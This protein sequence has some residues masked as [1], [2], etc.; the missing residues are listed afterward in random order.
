VKKAAIILAPALLVCA[1]LFWASP[2][3]AGGGHSQLSCGECHFSHRPKD[4]AVEEGLGILWRTTHTADGLPSFRPYSSRSFDALRTDIG[5]PDGTSKLCLGCH[6]GSYAGLSSRA[7]FGVSDLSRSHPVSF[8]YDSALASRVRAGRLND[9]NTT[10]SG[11]GGTIAQDLLDQQGKMQCTSC[12]DVHASGADSKM[13][14]YSTN[15]TTGDGSRICRI[16]HN[17]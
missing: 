2:A 16:C 6:D 7:V 14:R 4:M 9:P 13:L 15:R 17:M 1:G 3:G 12:H 5:Q 11:L 10:P 8:T